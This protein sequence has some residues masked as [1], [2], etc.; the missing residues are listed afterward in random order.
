[1]IVTEEV[2]IKICYRNRKYYLNKGYIAD[3]VNSVIT[4]KVSDLLKSSETI[5]ECRCD[6][7]DNIKSVKYSNRK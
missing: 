4:V 7:C 2:Q 6:Y 5:V 3:N 1:M